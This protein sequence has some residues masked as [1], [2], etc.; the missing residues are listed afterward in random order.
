MITVN[1]RWT[2]GYLE[3]FECEESRA[4]RDLLWIKLVNKSNRYI[5]LREVRWFSI[6]PESRE[7]ILKN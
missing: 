3:T 2:D 4:G 7:Q 1:V 6:N 5:P